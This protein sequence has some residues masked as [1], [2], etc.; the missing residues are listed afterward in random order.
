MY[1]C[2]RGANILSRACGVGGTRIS[3]KRRF[4]KRRS[5]QVSPFERRLTVRYTLKTR[6]GREFPTKA[7]IV[8]IPRGKVLYQFGFSGPPE[9]PD[10]ITTEVD[11]V[12]TSVRFVE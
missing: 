2:N 11:A 12:L 5:F 8:M 9:G 3:A 6:D 10:A 7:T 1:A 4:I